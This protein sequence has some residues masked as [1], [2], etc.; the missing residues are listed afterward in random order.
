M[1]HYLTTASYAPE[2][3]KAQ[4]ENPQDREAH[5]RSLIEGAG[6]Q[7]HAWYYA[8]G[9]HDLVA[10]YELPDNVSAASCL[11]AVAAGGSASKL[12]T[13]V[14]ITPDEGAEAIQRAKNVAYRPPS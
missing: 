11:I 8:F 12:T 9:E 5:L 7:L 14:L 1:P 13:T 4:I 3:W 10:I 6:G 2:A